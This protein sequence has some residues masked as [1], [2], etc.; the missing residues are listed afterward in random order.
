MGRVWRVFPFVGLLVLPAPVESQVEPAGE[1]LNL[2]FDCQAPSC[3]D[4]DYF[5]RELP[6]VNW[7]LDREVADVHLLIRWQESGG[8][9]RV[10]TLSFIGLD[11]F[12]GVEHELTLDTAGGATED[13][14]RAAIAGR[15]RLGLVTY[16]QRTPAAARLE[17]SYLSLDEDA[18][19]ETGTTSA[20]DDPWNFWVFRL[21]SNAFLN[22]Q[23]SFRSS[24]IFGS[25]NASR[26]TEGWK[27]NL[28][29]DYSRNAQE[30]DIPQ[31]DGSI[32]SIEEIRRD[33]GARGLAVRTL[34]AQWAV[35]VRADVG[36]STFFNQSR[37]WSIKPGIE[38]NLFPYAES[39]RRSLALQYLVGP[40]HFVYTEETIFGHTEETRLRHGLTA[41]LDLVQPW[42]RWDTSITGQQFLHDA[43]KYN[44]T[45]SGNVN[46]RLFRGFSVRI[47]GR[48]QWLRDQLY[49]P[50]EGATQEE[51]L[52]FQQQLETNY[53][54][55][56]SFGIEYRFG[57]IFNNVVNPRFGRG[58]GRT[59]FF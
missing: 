58:Q 35:G 5:R 15:A 44:F 6:F 21:N 42:G 9:G 46:I 23:S 30:F 27:L 53:T 7:V 17:V 14:E 24:N 52:L 50:A 43:G 25:F 59:G 47:G 12:E 28:G 49:I 31:S 22:G 37:R 32:E 45:V 48:Y 2:F 36:S 33:W 19:A 55:F 57:S 38:Y 18:D 16:A 54:Y 4:A 41:A 26:T 1:L 51:I 56:T 29:L 39:D 3:R 13:E 34:G 10:F 11:A 40:T 8:G 20:E